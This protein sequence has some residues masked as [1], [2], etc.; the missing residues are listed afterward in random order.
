MRNQVGIYTKLE[1]IDLSKAQA[2]IFDEDI[3]EEE[4][5][6]LA[7]KLDKEFIETIMLA[8]GKDFDSAKALI[9]MSRMLYEDEREANSIVIH[10]LNRGEFE[11]KQELAEVLRSSEAG[12]FFIEG[13]IY[14]SPETAIQDINAL[15]STILDSCSYLEVFNNRVTGSMIKGEEF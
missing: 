11:Y 14:K 5:Y 10:K 15:T 12:R 7:E 13:E 1:L 4:A 2:M 6:A 8:E 9:R 3:S